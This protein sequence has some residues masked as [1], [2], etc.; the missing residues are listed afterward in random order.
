MSVSHNQGSNQSNKCSI[1]LAFEK[2]LKDHISENLR[3]R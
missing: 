2:E 3:E 1:N